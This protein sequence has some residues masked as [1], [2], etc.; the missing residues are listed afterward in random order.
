[1]KVRLVRA[2]VQLDLVSDDGDALRPIE[3]QP[4]TVPGSEWPLD[5]DKVLATVAEQIT[6]SDEGVP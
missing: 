6:P 3:I 4:I 1:M 5:L 2:V